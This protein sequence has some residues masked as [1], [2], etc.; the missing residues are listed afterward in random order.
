[1]A[2][3][4][5]SGG[6]TVAGGG[7]ET[8]FGVNT[9]ATIFAG[10]QLAVSSG[11]VDSGATISSGGATP[12]ETPASPSPESSPAAPGTAPRSPLP[13]GRGGVARLQAGAEFGGAVASGMTVSSAGYWRWVPGTP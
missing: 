8:V 10:A 11:G 7:V 6:T 4:T 12:L 9:A 3:G 1:V 2:G 5:A 13:L